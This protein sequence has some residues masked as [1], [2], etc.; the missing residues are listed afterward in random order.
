MEGLKVEEDEDTWTLA[1]SVINFMGLN[2]DKQDLI[3]SQKLLRRFPKPGSE[4]PLVVSVL[5]E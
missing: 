3:Y 2:L 1:P 4:A 5:H